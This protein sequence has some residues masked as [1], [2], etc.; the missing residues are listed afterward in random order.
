MHAVSCFHDNDLD[1]ASVLQRPRVRTRDLINSR[2]DSRTDSHCRWCT[3]IS[4][5]DSEAG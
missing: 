4:S 2:T 3:P 1:H 5:L